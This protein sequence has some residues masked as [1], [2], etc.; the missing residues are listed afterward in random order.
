[1]VAQVT[2]RSRGE[3]QGHCPFCARSLA[4]T[5]HHLIPRKVHRRPR[6]RR[7]YDAAELAR[8]VYCCRDCHDAIHATYPEMELASRLNSP[9]ALAQDAAL[10]RHFA[11]L[12][13]QRRA[14]G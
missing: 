13:R 3:V 5:F 12:A 9:A 6:F 4:L 1:M 7:R 8:G 14:P 2:A 11:W 10:Q